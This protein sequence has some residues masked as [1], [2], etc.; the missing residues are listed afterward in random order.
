MSNTEFRNFMSEIPTCVAVIATVHEQRIQACTVSS[1]ISFDIENPGVIVLL[2]KDSRTLEVI[3]RSGF[4]SASILA[5]NQSFFASY[6]SKQN[7]DLR[8]NHDEL[9]EINQEYGV[10]HLKDC[11]QFCICKLEKV[12]DLGNSYLVFGRV[13]HFN[14]TKSQSPLI[15]AKRTYFNLGNN[16][17]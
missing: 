15:Y 13:L 17:L 2:K 1:L 10:P 4:F 11:T 16:I 9:F 3:E 12:A 6:F 8:P 7:R 5:E 14:S